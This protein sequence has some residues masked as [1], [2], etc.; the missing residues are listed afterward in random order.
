MNDN[1]NKTNAPI[2]LLPCPIC[3]GD[4]HIF[5][6]VDTD[7]PDAIAWHRAECRIK[8]CVSTSNFTTPEQAAEIWNTR[9]EADALRA[10]VEGY[11]QLLAEAIYV[12]LDQWAIY[13][14]FPFG[15]QPGDGRI[16]LFKKHETNQ[17]FDDRDFDTVLEAYAAIKPNAAAG[18]DQK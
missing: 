17:S 2:K 8:R 5:W 12:E 14:N 10:E 16:R 3:N 18:E 7:E 6:D 4:A 1:E 11:R 13:N 15:K 9:N